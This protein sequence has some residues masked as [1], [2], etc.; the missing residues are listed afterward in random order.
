M[1]LDFMDNLP[2]EVLTKIRK[3]SAGAEN[4]RTRKVGCHYCG[5]CVISIYENSSGYAEVKCKKC[6]GEALYNIALRRNMAM[7]TRKSR[8]Y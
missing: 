4:L 2:E 3:H 7:M 6:G 8:Y 5:H 1:R